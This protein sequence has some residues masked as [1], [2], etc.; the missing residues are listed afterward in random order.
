M[1]AAL[2]LGD[3]LEE[4]KPLLYCHLEDVVDRLALIL[5]LECLTVIA[6]ALA[7]LAGDIDIGQKVHLYLDDAVALTRLAS[8]ALDVE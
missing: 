2:D 1:Q 7:D 4:L 5:D 8:A 6:L 3:V